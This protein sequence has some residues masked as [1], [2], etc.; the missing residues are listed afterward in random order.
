MDPLVLLMTGGPACASEVA[1]FYENGPF[2]IQDNIEN[3]TLIWNK[4]G[5]DQ[6]ASIIYIDLPVGTGFSYSTNSGDIRHDAE[7]V[8][9]DIFDFFQA[10]FTAHPEFAENDLYVMGESFGS[11]YVPAVAARLHE[12]KKLKQGLPINLK[13]FAIGSGLTHPNIRYESYADYALSMALI[14]DDDH[15]RLSKVFPAC[16]TAIELCG[17][18]GTVTC[19]AAYLVC[20]S[21]FNTI[22]AISGNINS[23]DIRKECNEDICYDFSNLEIYLNQTKVREALGVG[24]QKFLSCSPLVYEA[25]LMDWMESKENKI[26]RLLE[27]GIQILVYAGEFDLICNWLG[28]SMWTAALP[29]SG[30]IEYARA[31]WKKFE[32]NGIEAGLVTGFKNLNFVKVQDAG[33]MVAMDQPRI[34]LEMFRRW[35]RGIPLGNRIKLEY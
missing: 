34:A 20:Q 3:L 17:T 12:E 31:P 28:N 25:I 16:A 4:F 29:W 30:Q 21:I 26:A 32:V 23:F 2:K 13:G 35:T 6:E 24:N 10:F 22:L 19:I 1:M 15:K 14:A 27:D 11:H 7:G 8:S 18:K 33:H 5:W 9:E